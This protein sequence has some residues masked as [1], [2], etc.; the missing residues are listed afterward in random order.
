MEL[1]GSY[2]FRLEHELHQ[3]KQKICEVDGVQ[4]P[5]HGTSEGKASLPSLPPSAE[6]SHLAP[7][8]DARYST[9][10]WCHALLCFHV[11][12]YCTYVV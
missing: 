8:M 10:S 6:N 9:F 7:L 2:L 4:R 11:M 5:H 1:C 3:L 12:T